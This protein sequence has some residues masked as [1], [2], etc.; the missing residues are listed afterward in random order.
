MPVDP[1]KHP[2]LEKSALSGLWDH[3][4]GV[5]H[6]S[7]ICAY[8]YYYVYTQFY[9]CVYVYT[10]GDIDIDFVACMHVYD[11]CIIHVLMYRGPYSTAK[12]RLL[13]EPRG[14]HQAP[15]CRSI[16]LPRVGLAMS[17]PRPAATNSGPC[18][19]RHNTWLMYINIYV[20]MIYIY[21][22]CVYVIYIYICMNIY[23][24]YMYTYMINIFIY[25]I[26][27]YIR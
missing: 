9:P 25:M 23:M 19:G 26:Y 21:M 18:K 17:F 14:A 22:I 27:I 7:L 8:M 6:I 10:N 2:L 4:I 20:Y 13:A 24:M 11:I 5:I 3:N 1:L 16:A 12:S 15:G